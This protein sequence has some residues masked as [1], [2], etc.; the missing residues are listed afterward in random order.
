LYFH[1]I[2]QYPFHIYRLHTSNNNVRFEKWRQ[3]GAEGKK[4]SLLQAKLLQY[5]IINPFLPLSTHNTAPT[6]AIFII[7]LTR[8]AELISEHTQ[9][10]PH[11]IPWADQ[12]GDD[13]IGGWEDKMKKM[14]E[15]LQKSLASAD[16]LATNWMKILNLK[17]KFL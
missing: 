6:A 13:W 9:F 11:F 3:C 16:L 7:T 12:L 1:V 15:K 4:R 10:F 8:R 5:Y 2:L 14:V 17:K